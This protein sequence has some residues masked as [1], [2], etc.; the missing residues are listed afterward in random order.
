MIEYEQWIS[1]ASFQLALAQGA[2]APSLVPLVH[3]RLG[4]NSFKL[5]WLIGSA[6]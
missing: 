4:K 3:H 6:P 5:V 1:T 2:S